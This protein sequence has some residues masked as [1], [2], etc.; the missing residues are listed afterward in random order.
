MDSKV[1]SMHLQTRVLAVQLSFRPDVVVTMNSAVDAVTKTLAVDPSGYSPKNH[2][3]PWNTWAEVIDCSANDLHKAVCE[4]NKTRL[5][6][7]YWAIMSLKHSGHRKMGSQVIPAINLPA[8]WAFR[9]LTRAKAEPVRLEWKSFAA[10]ERSVNA[11]IATTSS[12]RD[13]KTRRTSLKAATE[14]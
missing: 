1:K 12:K 7:F 14:S 4:M 6:R 2:G 13:A 8:I 11:L 10:F 3:L 9:A 5:D